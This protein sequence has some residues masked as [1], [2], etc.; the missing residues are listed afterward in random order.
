MKAM[1]AH[2]RLKGE[3]T[4]Y[5]K[6]KILLT[7][8]LSAL[9]GMAAASSAIATHVRP[10]AGAQF[11]VPMVVAYNACASPNRTHGPTLTA[12]SCNPPVQ[13]SNW[14]TLGTLDVT[15]HPS[16]SSGFVKV[17]VCVNGTTLDG[18]CSTP[19]GMSVPDARFEANITDV[20]CKVGGPSQSNCEG[21]Q[22]S[23]YVGEVQG[24]VNIR[25]TDHHNNVTPGGTGDTATVTD[26]PFPG[27]F[28][29]G[30][31]AN[32]AGGSQMAIGGTC[33]VVTAWNAVQPGAIQMFKRGNV[34]FDQVRVFDGGQSGVAG[35]SDATLF[36][37]Q[38]V[39]FP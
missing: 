13:S 1:P 5:L 6:K 8:A 18:I 32:P 22:F 25:I 36:E 29:A 39:F 35:A 3:T 34:E 2:R 20:R 37:V 33:S 21:G 23:D 12:P 26:L 11:R 16:Q 30:C 31:A 27:F 7:M 14:L 19:P 10:A 15:G 17:T 28:T 38:G 9:A 4:H 24:D